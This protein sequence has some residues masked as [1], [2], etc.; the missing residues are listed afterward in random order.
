MKGKLHTLLISLLFLV[1]LNGIALAS[2]E[3]CSESINNLFMEIASYTKSSQSTKILG[4]PI[5]AHSGKNLNDYGNFRLC[6]QAN[7]TSYVTLL[8]ELEFVK[9]ASFALGLCGP[10]NCTAADYKDDRVKKRLDFLLFLAG[11]QSNLNFSEIFSKVNVTVM[12]PDGHPQLTASGLLTLTITGLFVALVIIGT[13]YT[14]SHE[15]KP[16]Q[17]PPSSYSEL[18]TD[19]ST[20]TSNGSYMMFQDTHPV[21][22][23]MGSKVLKC[24]SVQ[25]NLNDLF[26][27]PRSQ[28]HDANLDILN[29]ARV[30]SIMWVLLGHE[31]A[32]T[33]FFTSNY[34]SIGSIKSDLFLNF[35]S[36]G[37][38]SV[39]TFFFLGGLLSAYVLTSKLKHHLLNGQTY[40]GIIL[41][42]VMR[43]L[44]AYAFV[45]FFFSRITGYF[46]SGPVWGL[47]V[48]YLKQ[49]DTNWW[50]NLLFVDNLVNRSFHDKDYCMG[51]SWYLSNDM[52]MFLL[53]P[54]IAWYYITKPQ[55]AFLVIGTLLIGSLS[56]G[57]YYSYSRSMYAGIEALMRQPEHE[58]EVYINPCVRIAPYLIGVTIG[59]FYRNY[60]EG[61]A[62]LT[63]F[64]KKLRSSGW[65]SYGIEFIGIV[66]VNLVI[67]LPARV[68]DDISLWPNWFHHA[69]VGTAKFFF[70]AGVALILLPGLFGARTLIQRVLAARF[71]TPLATLVF[72]TYLL[73]MVAIL[74]RQY[75]AKATFF[76]DHQTIL[77]DLIITTVFSFVGAAVLHLLVEAP[78]AKLEKLFHTPHHGRHVK[79]EHHEHSS[80]HI[81]K[82]EK[83][84]NND[85]SV[86]IRE[87]VT[88]KA[89]E[90][91]SYEL[92]SYAE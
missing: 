71:W 19:S 3:G 14:R 33:L 77:S 1:N 17:D 75:S 58:W 48:D 41:H 12:D 63:N 9:G 57:L 23:S 28:K 26:H 88:K 39:D 85:Q 16:E 86:K 54:I 92:P 81:V 64:A 43:I 68:Q 51:W 11:T 89:D 34:T 55:K 36:A 79:L 22:E 35:V 27:P 67:W 76:Y 29:G 7:N 40:F 50:K 59:L 4:L 10:A 38:Y 80:S 74:G 20:T 73:H 62:Y 30:L 66:V 24:W 49:C 5:V 72:L 83:I 70:A 21:R 25:E 8:V 46:G 53:T 37:F 15:E 90:G 31:Y 87:N 32:F 52:Q 60:K 82:E 42:R 13:I 47:Y 61:G 44:P 84:K 78:M 65:L 45:I 6:R 91:K 69:F 18:S 56:L 2:P